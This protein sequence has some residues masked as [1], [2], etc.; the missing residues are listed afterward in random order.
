MGDES[1]GCACSAGLLP[2]P[3]LRAEE[4]TLRD[5]LSSAAPAFD[6]RTE[7]GTQFLIYKLGSLEVRATR[8]LSGELSVGTVYDI[9]GIMQAKAAAGRPV[10]KDSEKIVKA[11]EFV[12][13][14]PSGDC[15]YYLTLDTEDNHSILIEKLQDG[16]VVWMESPVDLKMRSA[17]ARM[18]RTA[19]C[20]DSIV[21]VSMMRSIHEQDLSRAKPIASVSESKRYVQAAYHSASGQL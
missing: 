20:S 21:T 17:R 7:D 2:R 15:H 12:E 3:D 13:R 16:T 11:T 5:I 1:E 8:D 9:S 10:A 14:A 6:K 18:T 19:D 4:Q